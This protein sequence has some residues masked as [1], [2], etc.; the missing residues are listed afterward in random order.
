[1]TLCMLGI[2]LDECHCRV[3]SLKLGGNF[4]RQI[5]AKKLK[6]FICFKAI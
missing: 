1:M 5:I 3:D 4:G 2:F 6:L